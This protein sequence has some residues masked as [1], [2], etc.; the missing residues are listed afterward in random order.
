MG[1]PAASGWWRAPMGIR[2]AASQT[3]RHAGSPTRVLMSPFFEGAYA[4]NDRVIRLI[5]EDPELFDAMPARARR[6]AGA[7]ATASVLQLQ[8][9]SWSGGIAADGDPSS[10]LGVLV[11]EGVLI[12]NVRVGRQPRSELVGPGD[13]IRPWEHEGD[14]ASLPFAADWR[15][16]ERTRLAILDARCSAVASRWPAL[17]SVILGRAVRR[18]HALAL[19]L[20][21]SDV[22][23]IQERLLLFFW[24]LADRWGRVSRDGVTVPLRLTHE[25]IAQLVG[26]QRPTVTTALRTLSEAGLL[27]R[28]ADRTWL[29]AA[30]GRDA[31]GLMLVSRTSGGRSTAAPTEAATAPRE[32][33]AATG[34]SR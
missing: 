3:S 2:A 1:A 8:R 27:T 29:L 15:V 26:A 14:M 22:R 24:H 10:L 32:H 9:G 20:A 28:R 25:V 11:L 6:E 23:H 21:I 17:F 18:S 13:L 4:A 31:R 34:A 30:D 16:L 33:R 12:R 5:D 7:R 19:Q